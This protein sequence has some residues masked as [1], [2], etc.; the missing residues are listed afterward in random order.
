MPVWIGATAAVYEML[1]P[2]QKLMGVGFHIERGGP[3]NTVLGKHILLDKIRLSQ[4]WKT[5]HG[6]A[7][8][9]S[10]YVKYSARRKTYSEN[11]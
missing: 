5:G 2:G 4:S 6:F 10:I 7:K 9:V 1:N 3:G 11:S 8:H